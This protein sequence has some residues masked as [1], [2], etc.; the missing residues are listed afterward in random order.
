MGDIRIV[1]PGKT[2]E[3]SYPVCKKIISETQADSLFKIELNKT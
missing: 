1:G 2:H 3:Y